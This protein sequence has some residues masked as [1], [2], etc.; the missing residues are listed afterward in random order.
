MHRSQFS[1]ALAVGLPPRI[2]PA[3]QPQQP[4]AAGPAGGARRY[5]GDAGIAVPEPLLRRLHVAAENAMHF[6]S[7]AVTEQVQAIGAREIEVHSD[8]LER[9]LQSLAQQIRVEEPSANAG[10]H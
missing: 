1:C 5:P 8:L 10:K 3:R 2:P 9:R 6:A 4:C 7:A